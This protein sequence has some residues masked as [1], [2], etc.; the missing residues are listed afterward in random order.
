MPSISVLLSSVSIIGDEVKTTIQFSIMMINYYLL[1]VK[2]HVIKTYIY[3][4]Y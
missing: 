2:P 1:A 3:S 4:D